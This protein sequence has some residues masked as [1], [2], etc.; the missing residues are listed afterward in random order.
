MFLYFLWEIGNG[1]QLKWIEQFQRVDFL[2]KLNTYL[3][4]SGW[5]PQLV[6]SLPVYGAAFV[7]SSSTAIICLLKYFAILFLNSDAIVLNS[8]QICFSHLLLSCVSVSNSSTFQPGNS[9]SNLIAHLTL[10]LQSSFHSIPLYLNVLTICLY[11]FFTILFSFCSS[12]LFP[13]VLN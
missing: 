12:A 11:E 4:A 8:V 5:W 13:F 7:Y 10:R 2:E 1:L 6:I 3:H 9:I